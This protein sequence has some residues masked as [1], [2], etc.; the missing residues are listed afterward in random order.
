MTGNFGTQKVLLS[1][2]EYP[3]YSNIVFVDEATFRDYFDNDWFLGEW[4]ED[5]TLDGLI[6]AGLL[7]FEVVEVI[8]T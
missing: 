1:Y 3:S 8:G 7:G 5:Y 6:D 4:D 2:C